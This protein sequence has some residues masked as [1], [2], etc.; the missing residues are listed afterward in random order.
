MPTQQTTSNNQRSLPLIALRDVVVYPHMQIALFVGR[1][2]SV[3]A[4]EIAQA[5]YDN[6]V[7]VIAQK[8]SM[9]EE[10]ENDNLYQYGTVCRVINTMPHESDSSTIKVLIEGLYRAKLDDIYRDDDVFMADIS[11]EPIKHRI[12]KKTTTRI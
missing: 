3:N 10:I 9:S 4:V 5:D 2:A 7:F 12:S 1:S 8:D 11:E 6:Y